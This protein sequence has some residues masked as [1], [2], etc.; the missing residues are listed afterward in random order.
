MSDLSHRKPASAVTSSFTAG[1]LWNTI[2]ETIGIIEV[3]FV[4]QYQ[5]WWFENGQIHSVKLTALHIIPGTLKTVSAF[6][7]AT[8][9]RC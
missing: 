1:L 6:H 3:G 4:L 5:A 8:I 7:T 2:Q 9:S